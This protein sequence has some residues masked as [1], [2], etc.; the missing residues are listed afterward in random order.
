MS[1]KQAQISKGLVL[2][3][4]LDPDRAL[5]RFFRDRDW[6]VKTGVGGIFNALALAIFLMW[7]VLFPLSVILIALVQG[8]L[9]KT[10]RTFIK[11]KD[12]VLPAWN[13]WF[14][15][16][17][18]GMSWIALMTMFHFLVL[19]F[20]YLSLIAGSLLHTTKVGS[21]DFM[22][23]AAGTIIGIKLAVSFFMFFASVLMANFAEGESMPSGFA[24]FKVLKRIFTCPGDFLCAWILGIG[25][26]FVFFAVPCITL[27]GIIVLPTAI[28][29][30]QLLAVIVMAQ[31]WRSAAPVPIEAKLTADNKVE[32]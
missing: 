1:A 21:A 31:A 22:L 26:Q 5:K 17:V 23:W 15:L 3:S 18:S 19:S 12:A 28:F 13:D 9:L 27:V 30:S 16:F 25:I 11:D 10:L 7:P 4:G 2:N 20:A 32:E 14:D 29:T 6:T 24:Y 8:Y